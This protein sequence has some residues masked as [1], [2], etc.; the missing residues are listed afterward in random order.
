MSYMHIENLY[1]A[2]DILMFRECYALEKIHGS[3]AHVAWKDDTVALF[4]GGTSAASFAALFD[5]PALAAKFT[6][7]SHPVV[8]VYGEAYGG[9]MQGMK[10]TYGPTLRFV[11]F[12]IRIDATWL[13]VPDA[14][15]VAAGLGFDFV[16]WRKVVA[17]VPTLDAERDRLS[18]QSV[19]CGITAP[20]PREGIV[21][22]P[23]IELT[24]SNG[25]RII[26]KHK[27]DA[28]AERTHQPKVSSERLPVLTAANAVADEW[29]T[30]M[31]LAH[32]LD[33][34]AA[35]G[36]DVTAIQSTPQVIT[37]M[38]EDVARE[39]SGEIEVTNDVRRAVGSRAAKMFQE[40]LRA[41]LT[42]SK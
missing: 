26:T 4:A 22:R 3:S 39:A 41:A 12:E 2:Q 11:A 27:S 30:P 34:L 7:L 16:P 32:V 8:T 9:K 24:K 20:R 6:A 35:A 17:D 23:L 36:T 14:A 1:R 15:D 13:A 19:K 42:E 28:F 25:D 37:A 10:D 18:E 5:V 21:I 33:A 31:R 38:V 29:V 40:R